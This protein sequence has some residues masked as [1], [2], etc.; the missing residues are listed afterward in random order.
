MSN[1]TLRIRQAP[2][3]PAAE[4]HLVLGRPGPA[5]QCLHLLF[6]RA[7]A[8]IRQGL[9]LIFSGEG[10]DMSTVLRGAAHLWFDRATARRGAA[11]LWFDR[12]ARPRQ[13]LHLRFDRLQ[14]VRQG[15]HL[16]FSG[17]RPVRQGLHLRWYMGDLAVLR[18]GLHLIY[19]LSDRVQ[20]RQGL[21]LRFSG[22][23]QEASAPT[24]SIS[25]RPVWPVRISVT[26]D[27]AQAVITATLEFDEPLPAGLWPP[28]GV[29]IEIFG[30]PYVLIGE[31][32]ART[33]EFGARSWA[34]TASSPAIQLQGRS[35]IP[36]QGD[37]SGPA[38]AI[39]ARLA[40]PVPIAWRMVDW[41]VQPLRL[42]GTGQTPLDLLRTLVSAAGGAL[43]SQ[44][45]GSLLARPNPPL[46]PATWGDHVAGDLDSLGTMISVNDQ[47]D[48]R[49]LYDSVTVSDEGE[50]QNGL[51]L[52]EDRD[53]RVGDTT[54]V[55][56]YQVPWRDVFDL[57][58]CGN[59][60]IVVLANLGI[61]ERLVRDE[62][63]EI[64]EGQ[65]RTRYPIYG[66]V[67][68]RWN[69]T[70]LGSITPSEDGSLQTGVPRESLLYL[71]YRTKCRR[72]RVRGELGAEP[73][74]LVLEDDQ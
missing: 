29:E 1:F 65:G 42:V 49:Q 46:A 66:I 43:V 32:Y 59:Q 72:Y 31:Q 4:F 16:G 58:H 24:V 57:R 74:L 70:G 36:V 22:P 5:R 15:L 63:V 69:K 17:L 18:Q 9:H 55:L 3:A 8:E 48:E 37:L 53:R 44:P 68:G 7:R 52:E 12:A 62:L 28:A 30:R 21:H 35:A 51:R 39:A 40:A 71:T 45:D 23:G 56:A 38:S 26:E 6:G 47:A 2:A 73:L 19:H 27:A 61:E 50:S 54:E 34:L 14:Q 64:R 67:R 33:R 20:V 11:H 25:G 60:G 10:D 13:G 41:Q